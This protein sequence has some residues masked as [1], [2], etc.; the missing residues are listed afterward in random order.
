MAKLRNLEYYGFPEQKEFQGI[1]T[2]YSIKND[3]QDTEIATL[4]EMQNMG[5]ICHIT[6]TRSADYAE[7]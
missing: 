1:K 2:Q 6:M 3:E 7:V 4:I 5:T